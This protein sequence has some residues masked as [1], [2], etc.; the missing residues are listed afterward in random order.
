MVGSASHFDNGDNSCFTMVV[1]LFINSR[2]WFNASRGTDKEAFLQDTHG[3][4]A[5]GKKCIYY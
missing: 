3:Y 5:N 4:N 1:A 2:Y